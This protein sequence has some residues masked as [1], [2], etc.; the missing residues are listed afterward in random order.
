MKPNNPNPISIFTLFSS[1]SNFSQYIRYLIKPVF[2]LVLI[3]SANS[4]YNANARTLTKAD[5]ITMITKLRA[6]SA[7]MQA[8]T[9]KLNLKID[10][11]KKA[12]NEQSTATYQGAFT[13]GNWF[14]YSI[15]VLLCAFLIYIAVASPKNS[16]FPL[17]LPD[18]SIRG[19]IA[20]LAIILYVLISLTL[21]AV[22]PNSTIAADIT[23]TLGTLVVAIS[24]F[25]FGAKTAEQGIKTAALLNN[26]AD[27]STVPVN[28]IQQAITDNK[29][30]W[31]SL[32]NCT[33]I[34]LGK[35]KTQDTTH[36]IDCI[37]FFVDEKSDNP[38]PVPGMPV[39][40]KAIPAVIPFTFNKK[41]YNIPTDVQK[42][43]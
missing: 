35:K 7:N 20:I 25:Y 16:E 3:L 38:T 37:V 15:G 1:I 28:V 39:T 21:S 9:K 2:V 32:Y 33:N 17:G 24:A 31:M 23:K 8:V 34:V 11:L 36:D 42:N 29:K 40:P 14:I 12:I 43:P 19:I 22:P 13:T 6:D 26:N 18:G 10:T 5:T 4:F 41:V 27:E 30:D